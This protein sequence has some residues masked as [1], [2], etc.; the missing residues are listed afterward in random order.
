MH[1]LIIPLLSCALLYWLAATSLHQDGAYDQRDIDAVT[2][3]SLAPRATLLQRQAAALKE[4][5][6]IDEAEVD[7]KV[8]LW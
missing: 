3:L 6:Y 2:R 7:K 4:V 8:V 1:K 5:F